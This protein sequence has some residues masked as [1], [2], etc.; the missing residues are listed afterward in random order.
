MNSDYDQEQGADDDETGGFDEN[1][2]ALLKS[3]TE[4]IQGLLNNQGAQIEHNENTI[5]IL[6]ELAARI[7]NAGANHVPGVRKALSQPHR[8]IAPASASMKMSSLTRRER[9]EDDGRKQEITNSLDDLN[10]A[11]EKFGNEVE[12]RESGG[13]MAVA[14]NRLRAA[15]ARRQCELSELPDGSKKVFLNQAREFEERADMLEKQ[16]GARGAGWHE[17]QPSP[18]EFGSD[19]QGFSNPG[20]DEA[21]EKHVPSTLKGH[22]ETLQEL[23][24]D[25]DRLAEKNENLLEVLKELAD[26]IEMTE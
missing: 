19:K 11:L 26:C 10:A 7:E 17:R 2:L 13:R 8:S 1:V 9:V 24:E 12:E 21:A 15:L 16:L 4:A 20:V 18:K 3:H 6:K 25:R 23:R 5:E 22:A 14:T